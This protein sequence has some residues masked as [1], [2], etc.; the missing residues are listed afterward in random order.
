[1]NMRDLTTRG[2]VTACALALVS[3]WGCS[4]P[5]EPGQN[6]PMDTVRAECEKFE[7]DQLRQRIVSYRD[8]VRQKIQEQTALEDRAAAIDPETAANEIAKLKAEWDKLDKS[9]AALMERY[10]LYLSTYR[11]NS[12]GDLSDLRIESAP[13]Q[14]EPPKP[15]P[16]VAK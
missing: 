6:V 9:R 14:P 5:M 10:Q 13:P 11:N 7:P 16:P 8:L 4:K 12:G 1:M 3:A 2:V 15:D